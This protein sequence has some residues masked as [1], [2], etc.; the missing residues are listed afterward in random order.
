MVSALDPKQLV[1]LIVWL[2]KN[3]GER[4]STLRL[5]KFLYL[6]D[7]YW[8]REHG[9]RTLTGWPWA[10]VHFG[11]FCGESLD[12]IQQAVAAGLVSA[13]PFQ[14]KYTADEYQLYFV[15]DDR[16]GMLAE[17]VPLALLGPLEESIRR[18]ADDTPGLLDHV[19]FHTE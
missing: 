11:P 12:T 10:F 15:D 16:A 9:G 3:R 19:Y 6:A 8:A 2:A 1:Q 4:L 14:S 13:R 18:W 7:L 5:V 17:T